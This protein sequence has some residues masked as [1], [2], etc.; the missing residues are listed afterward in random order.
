MEREGAALQDVDVLRYRQSAGVVAGG[1]SNPP[2]LA[3]PLD[4]RVTSKSRPDY[5]SQLAP[6]STADHYSIEHEILSS[7]VIG[8]RRKRQPND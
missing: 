8:L 2:W 7:L 3:L 1:R 6:S 4:H 5:A